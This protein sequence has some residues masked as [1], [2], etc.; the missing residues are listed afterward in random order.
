MG[1]V[2]P[3]VAWVMG[4]LQSKVWK[5]NAGNPGGYCGH[6]ADTSGTKWGQIYL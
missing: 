6:G 1:N 2:V 3:E 5:N 4:A